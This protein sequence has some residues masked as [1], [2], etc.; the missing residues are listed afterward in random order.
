MPII[1]PPPA[2]A[3]SPTY[4]PPGYVV[5]QQQQPAPS[6]NTVI[7]RDSGPSYGGAAVGLAAGVVMGAAISDLGGLN[8]ILVTFNALAW[9]HLVLLSP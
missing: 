7:V 9:R 3:Y 5:H 8:T 2:P 1:G 6:T 4:Y